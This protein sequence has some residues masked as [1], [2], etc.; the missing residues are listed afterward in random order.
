LFQ[1][2]DG[3]KG[4]CFVDFKGTQSNGGIGYSKLF[5][6]LQGIMK[7][8]GVRRDFLLKETKS[9]VLKS[10]VYIGREFDFCATGNEEKKGSHEN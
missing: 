8:D 5:W 1:I 10:S 7:I 4:C 6:L 2:F 9:K 3:G